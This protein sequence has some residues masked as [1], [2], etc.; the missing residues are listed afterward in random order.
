ME[1]ID[2]TLKFNKE[3]LPIRKIPASLAELKK[4]V[5]KSFGMPSSNLLFSILNSAGSKM[6]VRTQTD[7]KRALTYAGLQ[8]V[9]EIEEKPA[10]EETKEEEISLAS[11]NKGSRRVLLAN[12]KAIALANN[13]AD[14]I[15]DIPEDEMCN[16]CY[17]RFAEPMAA[18]CG[19]VCC[20]KCWERLLENALECP[21]CKGR[22]RLN[23]LRKVQ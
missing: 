5:K 18:K 12:R 10:E 23:H 2:C 1:S 22:V 7:Y 9:I 8:V 15:E 21:L 11:L 17:G 16:I 19:H 13:A 6:P 14:S 20:R 4:T 3:T